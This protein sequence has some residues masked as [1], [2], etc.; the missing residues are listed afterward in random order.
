M[1][2][3][4]GDHVAWRRWWF[5][6]EAA[7][8][9][10]DGLL[11]DPSGE[12]TRYLNPGAARLDEYADCRGIILLADAGMGK[13]FELTAEIARR[14]AAGQH[15]ARLDLGTYLSAGEVKDAV[16]GAVSAW[17]A[18]GADDLALALD[19]FDEPI[20]EIRNLSDVLLREPPGR[21]R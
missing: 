4:A 19:G 1:G 7:I 20:L 18:S 17:E 11:H 12:Y 8:G 15:V 13:S 14:R 21:K 10:S 6:D 2:F 9:M 5:P 3:I 16:R